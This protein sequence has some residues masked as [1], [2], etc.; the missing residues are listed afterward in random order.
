M[1]QKNKIAIVL[2]LML[3]AIAIWLIMRNNN[4]T[5]KQT[6]KDFAVKDTTSIDKV[7]LAD[8]KGRSI[9]LEK[10]SP[11]KWLVNG[12]YEA[13]NDAVQTLIYTI[14]KVEVK[15]PVSKKAHDNI[16]KKLAAEAVKCE[17]YSGGKLIKAYYVGSETQ[18]MTGTYM[19]LIDLNTMQTS[20]KPFVTYIPGFQG[21]LTTRY[22]TEEIGWRDRTVFNYIPP[23]IKSVRM[24]TPGAPDKSFEVLNLGENL[25][26]IKLLETGKS[27]KNIDTIA[28]KQYLSY[29]QNLNFESFEVEMSPQQMDSVK[30]TTPTNIITV[31]LQNGEKNEVKFYPRKPK[32]GVTEIDGK[33]IE[34]DPDR[35]NATMNNG[36][37]FVFVQYFMFGKIMPSPDYF[38]KK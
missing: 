26:D 12:K 4:S 30:Q 16:V 7:F 31:T 34:F 14:N 20:A 15:E 35:M 3:G 9:T 29:F 28:I 2:F 18:D 33:K 6:L 22:F 11:G 32:N 23:D 19:I 24:E 27:L 5:I 37:D 10:Q 13:R 25:F 17:I 36:K 1:K 21:F 38:I 8:K